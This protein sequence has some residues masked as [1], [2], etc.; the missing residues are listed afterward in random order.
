M[1]TSS[2]ILLALAPVLA[3]PAQV[4]HSLDHGEI[5]LPAQFVVSAAGVEH[6]PDGATVPAIIGWE[7]IDL[8]SLAKDAPAV[9]A[10][11]K[12]ALLVGERVYF[13]AIVAASPA[14]AVKGNAYRS[15][16]EL[17]VNVTFNGSTQLT[18]SAMPAND[19]DV[20][21]NALPG[22]R[23]VARSVSLPAAERDAGLP[24]GGRLPGGVITSTT[25]I[26]ET[27]RAPL[28]TNIEGLFFIIGNDGNSDAADLIHV[29]QKRPGFFLGLR[30]NLEL[31]AKAYPQDIEITS[32]IKAVSRFE[33]G[34]AAISVDAQRTLRRFIE[35]CRNAGRA[36]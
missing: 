3:L 36:S 15:F 21:A 10:A 23:A 27:T 20:R 12:K 8:A 2:L 11:R 31:L 33:S 30:Q 13:S 7:T 14:A 17:P 9:E 29:L 25:R 34:D 1:K 19:G 18:T 22:T 6:V 32:A 35:H 5:R 4:V 16:L 24:N 26:A 28:V